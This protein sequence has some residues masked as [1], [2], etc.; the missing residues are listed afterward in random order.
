VGGAPGGGPGLP[1]NT[2][3]VGA[4]GPLLRYNSTRKVWEP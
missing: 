1:G 4:D 2:G 3:A